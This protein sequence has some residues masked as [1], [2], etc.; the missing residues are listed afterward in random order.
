MIAL[1]NLM[2]SNF[3]KFMYAVW[4]T[5]YIADAFVNGTSIPMWILWGMAIGMGVLWLQ[6]FFWFISEYLEV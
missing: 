5:G 4:S 6:M 1:K 2:K 3:M